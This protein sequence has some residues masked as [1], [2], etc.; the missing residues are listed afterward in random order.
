MRQAAIAASRPR[1]DYP[2]VK[3]L[4][5]LP[6]LGVVAWSV[7]AHPWGWLYGLGVHP[8]PASSSTPWTYQMWSGI[9]PALTVVSLFTAMGGAWHHANCHVHGCWRL[10]KF[11]V[12]EGAFRVCLRHHPDEGV[13]R[14]LTREH[15]A[16]LHR[17][18]S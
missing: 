4:L 15:I 13:R 16:V 6:V 11:P 2:A 8:Y 14:G 12:A 3:K 10:G 17:R 5:L 1:S 18:S 9:L 7:V